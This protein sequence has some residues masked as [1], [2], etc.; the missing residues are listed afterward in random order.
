MRIGDEDEG[1]TRLEGAV[2]SPTAFRVWHPPLR[3]ISS[4]TFGPLYT[5]VSL[6]TDCIVVAGDAC[7]GFDA[8]VRARLKLE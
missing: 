1:P 5:V 8:T 4:H 2:M 6:S 3:P 7:G